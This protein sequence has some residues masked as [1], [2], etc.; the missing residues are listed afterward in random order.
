MKFRWFVLE[1]RTPY[2]A[3]VEPYQHVAPRGATSSRASTRV[4]IFS[5]SPAPLFR[6]AAPKACTRHATCHAKPRRA[7]SDKHRRHRQEKRA[8]STATHGD[9]RRRTATGHEDKATSAPRP[10]RPRSSPP[11]QLVANAP[12][13]TDEQ[14]EKPAPPAPPRAW[15]CERMRLREIDTATGTAADAAAGTA[16]DT[17]DA[18]AQDTDRP[19]QHKLERKLQQTRTDSN[20]LER[21]CS[22]ADRRR[23]HAQVPPRCLESGRV[24]VPALPHAYSA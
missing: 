13:A 15:A 3:C 17:I 7:K 10:G 5:V 20:K 18:V 24:K 14:R 4:F 21:A 9:A 22:P 23:R 12:P 11:R 6:P 1:K 16:A 8:E 2:E 19:T